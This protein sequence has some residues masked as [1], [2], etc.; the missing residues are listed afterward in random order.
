MTREVSKMGVRFTVDQDQPAGDWGGPGFWDWFESETWEPDTARVLRLCLDSDT[1]YVDV[2]AWI[3]DTVLLGAC[4]AGSVIAFEPDP[5][6]RAVLK[7]NLSLNPLMENVQVRDEALSDRSGRGGLVYVGESGDSLTQLEPR[8]I[9]AAP[10]DDGTVSQ[11]DV[12]EFP[13]QE[14]VWQEVGFSSSSTLRDLN[15]RSS[16]R[17]A[18]ISATSGRTSSSRFIPT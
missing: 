4:R 3:G 8:D 12:R 16:P 17:C 14:P 6:A 10:G 5:T 2:G 7:R 11:L 9:S 13:A 18:T 1:T 15:T